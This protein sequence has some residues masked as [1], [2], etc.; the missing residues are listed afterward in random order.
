MEVTNKRLSR[1]METGKFLGEIIIYPAKK[2][3]KS[4]QLLGKNRLIYNLYLIRHKKRLLIYSILGIVWEGFSYN[5]VTGEA[6]K[7][8]HPA[9][10]SVLSSLH[11]YRIYFRRRLFYIFGGGH[12]QPPPAYRHG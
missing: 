9:L 10:G 3:S 12:R 8:V 1:L 6:K 4:D 2:C 11:Y 5:G 7:Y